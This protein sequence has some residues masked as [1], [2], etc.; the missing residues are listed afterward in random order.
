MNS[1]IP[2]MKRAAAA[3]EQGRIPYVLGGSLGA[4]ARGSPDTAADLDF[5][6]KPEDAE[7]AL[8]A[9]VGVGMREERPP[10]QWLFKA[11]DGDVLVD[12]IFGP[13]GVEITD[14]VIARGERLGVAG[15]SIPVMA[16]EDL[17]TTVLMA[18]GEHSL[19]Y[20]HPLQM[21]RSL[22][23]QVD[24]SEVSART[25]GSPYARAFFTLIEELGI[26]GPVS[27][28][29]PSRPRIRIAASEH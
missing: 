17:L 18:M 16:V 4:W 21:A 10:E 3:L 29:E 26:A 19:D 13:S 25:H 14:D 2:T 12:L 15:M 27:E 1:L 24:W 23:E 20:E 28:R 5:M 11:W 22:R 8:T 6:V 7:R 9:L